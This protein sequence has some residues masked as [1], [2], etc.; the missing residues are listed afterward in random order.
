[1]QNGLTNYAY[2]VLLH[3][4]GH[5]L[6]LKHPFEGDRGNFST[7]NTLEDR[8]EFTAMSY[9]DTAV[10][11]NGTFRSLDWMALTKLYGVNPAFAAENNVYKFSDLTG[12]FIIDG[13][14]VDTISMV[15]SH[16]NIFIDLR[17]GA[18]SYEGQKSNYITAAHQLTISHGSE[19]ENVETGLGND[20]IIGNKLSNKIVSNAGDDIIFA[21]EGEDIVVPGLGSDTIDF[22][23]TAQTKDIIVL[24]KTSDDGSTSKVYGFVQGLSGDV[25]NIA[26]FN[27]PSLT[28]LPIVDV[29]DVPSGYI[30]NCLVRVFG[31]DLD[32]VTNL[33]PYFEPGSVLENLKLSDEKSA[34]IISAASQDT[35]EMQ[36]L[37][38]IENVYGSIEVFSEI[39][40]L[41]NYLDIDNWSADNF[42]L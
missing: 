37:H 25:V 30:D 11:F 23:E 18:H 22:S 2:E 17:P 40:F 16:K 4:I 27:L 15:K 20:T 24:E 26:D 7:L 13:N 38:I 35:G 33:Q 42:L 28:V 39:Q 31:E 29:L 10:T 34:I 3:E 14:G 5:A 9:E 19:I 8:T 21:G 32:D 6:G 41:G 12:V 1:M 36:K